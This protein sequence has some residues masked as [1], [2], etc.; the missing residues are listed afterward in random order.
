M[1]FEIETNGFLLRT[2]TFFLV[3]LTSFTSQLTAQQ[4]PALPPK[5]VDGILAVV[6]EKVIL[7]SD[8]ETEKSANCSRASAAR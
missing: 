6:G 2:I 4:G 1:K 3:A 7:A 8:Y 5:F